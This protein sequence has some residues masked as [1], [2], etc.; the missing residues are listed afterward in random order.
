MFSIGYGA[1]IKSLSP[2]REP[3]CSSLKQGRI[4]AISSAVGERS[5]KPISSVI[6]IEPVKQPIN[7][8]ERS[9]CC[10]IAAVSMLSKPGNDGM[11]DSGTTVGTSVGATV[12]TRVGAK[13][14]AG[15]AV[16]SGSVTTATAAVPAPLEQA[17]KNRVKIVIM[18]KKIFRAF[19]S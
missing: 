14:G 12:G 16:G 18:G 19:M 13:I 5:A 9:T 4:N 1:G 17:N 6:L 3:N 2:L 8:G 7:S 15:T 11:D 10:I